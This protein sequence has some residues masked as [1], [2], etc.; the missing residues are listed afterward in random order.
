MHA[1]QSPLPTIQ[2]PELPKRGAR[3]YLASMRKMF[4]RELRARQ[5]GNR[6]QRRMAARTVR[7]A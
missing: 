5:I 7:F 1:E 2:R 4:E 6:A 3:R